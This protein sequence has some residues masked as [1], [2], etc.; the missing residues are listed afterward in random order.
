MTEYTF[1]V[2]EYAAN[3]PWIVVDQR[4]ET[5]EITDGTPFWTWALKKYPKSR[6]EIDIRTDQLMQ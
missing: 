3:K 2:R 6:F 4:Q 1:W 5:V